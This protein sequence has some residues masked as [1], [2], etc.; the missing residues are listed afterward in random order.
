MSPAEG[1]RNP[2]AHSLSVRLVSTTCSAVTF[3]TFFMFG[4]G[5]GLIAFAVVSFYFLELRLALGLIADAVVSR[6]PF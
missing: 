3:V 4:I 5:F 6:S 2:G 1:F